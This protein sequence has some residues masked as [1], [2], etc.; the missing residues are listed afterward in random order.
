MRGF[1]LP[2]GR[3][4]YSSNILIERLKS[5]T[6][7][8]RNLSDR[9]KR[10]LSGGSSSFRTGSALTIP[11]DPIRPLNTGHR[12]KHT[13]LPKTRNEQDEIK[14]H[15][16]LKRHKIVRLTENTTGKML[17]CHAKW[18]PSVLENTSNTKPSQQ[19]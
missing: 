6:K 19:I 16:P 10:W 9:T 11:T 1:G 12:S 18:M 2:D 3:G 8:R 15:T 17:L 13:G 14:R 7:A 5:I 4:R